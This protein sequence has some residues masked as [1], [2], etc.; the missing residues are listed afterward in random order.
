VKDYRVELDVY[1][2]PLD[3]LLFLIRRD[4]V[5][6]YDIPISRVTEQYVSYVNVL[7]HVDP[8]AV[9]DF[10]VMAATL[11]EIK[12]RMLLPSPPPEEDTQDDFGDPRLELVRQLLEYKSFKDAARSLDTA[13][14]I[15]ALK[16]PRVPVDALP[17][18]NEVDIDEVQIW[19]LL[20]A[21]Q[22]VLDAT[23]RRSAKHEVVYDDTPI[24]LHAADILDA[25]QRSGGRH[26][27]QALF[28]GRDK[29]QM[30][31]L[32]LALLELLRQRRLRAVQS[33]GF[34]TIELELLDDAPIDVDEADYTSQVV[35]EDA[36]PSEVAKESAD[37]VAD[38]QAI[39]D[40]SEEPERDHIERNAIKETD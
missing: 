24:A 28:A 8:D 17:A 30:I 32:F 38:R 7:K 3:L 1:N 6:V 11:M 40:A 26:G 29:G 25:L 9:G 18:S 16:H 20:D 13:M 2:G 12:S 27:F 39:S 15:Q 14:Q 35:G 21:F 23:G 34:S 36:Q 10:L 37:L 22:K 33:A 4:E 5:D 31:G 19:D